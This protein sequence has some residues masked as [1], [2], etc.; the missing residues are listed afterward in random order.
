[1]LL[2]SSTESLLNVF[3]AL[4]QTVLIFVNGVYIEAEGTKQ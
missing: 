2:L 1:P 3:D 4:V